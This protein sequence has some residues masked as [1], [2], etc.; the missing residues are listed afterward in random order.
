MTTPISPL[1]RPERAEADKS[2]LVE[3]MRLDSQSRS[4]RVRAGLA[5]GLH[6]MRQRPRLVS[7]SLLTTLLVVV[8]LV[9]FSTLTAPA[10]RPSTLTPNSPSRWVLLGDV[11][12]S[13]Q[14]LS[15]T[16]YQPQF[17]LPGVGFSC[18]STTT[19]YAVNFENPGPNGSSEVVVTTDGGDTWSPSTL[20]VTLTGPGPAA[21]SCSDATT[22][23]LLG[24]NSAGS[25]IFLETTDTGATWQQEAGPS[26]LGASVG[27]RLV[28][29]S[30]TTCLGVTG[31]GG[32]TTATSSLVT[33]NA[34]SPFA[35]TTHNAGVTWTTSSLPSGFVPGDLQCSSPEDCV[36]SGGGVP[37]IASQGTGFTYT[38]NGGVT[39]TATNAPSSS[40]FVG[41]R[42]LSCSSSS[43]CL[44]DVDGP[45]AGTSPLLSSSD[46]GATWTTQS[47]TGLPQGF[48]TTLSCTTGTMC[49]A[50]GV[51]N[52]NPEVSAVSLGAPGFVA[53]TSDGGATWQSSS[54]PT[55]VGAVMELSCPSSTACFALAV[56]Q[57]QTAG[58]TAG[59]EIL[60]YGASTTADN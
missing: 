8:A 27:T 34:Q 30:A 52:S 7:L 50:G 45:G 13:W 11:S 57:G 32:P 16:A 19:C 17:G 42:R 39:W 36:A 40:T 10:T 4:H 29:S 2:A 18:P 55:G 46:A 51:E 54:L 6:A 5:T 59:F 9:V 60:A 3:A 33:A 26:G 38:S 53:S 12:P 20:P 48:V 41:Q 22:C 28:C 37:G 56:S 23:A 47:E 31:G 44:S 25:P 21:L 15:G 58:T 35:F 24:V 49:W 1:V 43:T 14:A